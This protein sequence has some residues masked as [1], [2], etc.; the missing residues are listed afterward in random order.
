MS[1]D[2][3][4]LQRENGWE[5]S[6]KNLQCSFMTVRIWVETDWNKRWKRLWCLK[7]ELVFN[8]GRMYLQRWQLLSTCVKNEIM[9]DLLLRS[10]NRCEIAVLNV[11]MEQQFTLREKGNSVQWTMCDEQCV[12]NVRRWWL[13][14]NLLVWLDHNYKDSSQYWILLSCSLRGH[15]SQL[16]WARHMLHNFI[17]KS[18]N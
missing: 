13:L 10:W 8:R 6:W 2:V 16:G 11:K 3:M 12:M 18:V 14:C 4:T 5:L 15:K 9:E 7:E 1:C 17:P